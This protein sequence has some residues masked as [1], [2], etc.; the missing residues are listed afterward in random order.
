[1][2]DLYHENG[3]GCMLYIWNGYINN[4]LSLHCPIWLGCSFSCARNKLMYSMQPD[5]FS[6]YNFESGVQD[7][8]LLCT[9]EFTSLEVCSQQTYSTHFA[10]AVCVSRL[11]LSY[12]ISLLR[13]KGCFNHYLKFSVTS[14]ITKLPQWHHL[15]FLIWWDIYHYTI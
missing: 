6:W 14:G 9:T 7:Y 4:D 13:S 5:P 12:C 11:H 15:L 3:C 8:L 1:M 2:P 10:C